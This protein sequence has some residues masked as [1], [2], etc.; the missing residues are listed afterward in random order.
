MLEKVSKQEIDCNEITSLLAK[1]LFHTRAILLIH[2][3]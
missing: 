2:R 3:T 1:A